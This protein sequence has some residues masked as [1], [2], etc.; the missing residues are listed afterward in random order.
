MEP[1][2]PLAVLR[3]DRPEK[4]NAL[5]PAMLSSLRQALDNA[6]S[7]RAIILSGSGD[8][9]CS[10]F[11]LSA[12][13]DDGHVL[14]DL[15]RALDAACRAMRA[16]PAPIVVSAHGAAIAGGCA[17]V[18]ASDVA[19]A[20]SDA[21]IG[22]P[23]VRL[24]I[25]PAVSAPLLRLAVGDGHARERLLD[26]GVVTGHEAK[27]LGLLADTFSTAAQCEA[28]AIETARALAEHPP[29][30]VA[31]TKRWLNQIDGSDNNDAADAAVEAS[32]SVAGSDEQRLLLDLALSSRP[33]P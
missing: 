19:Y 24:G 5:T 21:R 4:R 33:T 32:L 12:C 13:R 15:L 31:Y 29:H 14:P 3:F 9:F 26:P 1:L 30:A 25:S 23:A 11:D 7:A 8:Y 27:R 28:R 2:G 20:T 17:L 16:H 18:A 22:Y 10:G 6:M